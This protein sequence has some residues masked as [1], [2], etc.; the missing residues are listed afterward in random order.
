MTT[1]LA[2][3]TAIRCLLPFLAVLGLVMMAGA[4]DARAY[5]NDRL[6]QEADAFERHLRQNWSAEDGSAGDYRERGNL[7][8]KENMPRAATGA[9]ASAV[10]L[11]KDDATTWLALA[12]AYLAIDP[13]N[14]SE[15]RNFSE[16]ATSAAYLAYQRA[17]SDPLRAA[18]LAELGEGLARRSLWRPAIDAYAASLEVREAKAVRAAYEKLRAERGFRVL[19]Y[20]V[21][22]DAAAPRACVQFSERLAKGVDFAKYI[23]LNGADPAGVAVDDQQVCVEELRH[24][25]RYSLRLRQGLPSAVGETLLKPADLSIYV[26]DRSPSARF[27]GRNYVLPRTGQKGLPVVTVNARELDMALYRI[28]DRRLAHEV[29][30][31][32]FGESLAGYRAEEIKEK[33]GELLWEGQM[34]VEMELNEEVTTAFPV[35]ELQSDLEPGLYVVTAQPASEEAEEWRDRATQWFVISDIGLSAF[36]GTDGI[37]VFARSLASA[38]SLS[39]LEVRLLA[40]NNEVL[41]SVR[42]DESGY[43]SFDPGLTRGEGG[44][45]PAILVAR[46]PEGDYGFLD[47]TKSAFDL[48][49]RGV[50]GRAAPGPLDAMVYAERGV[51]RPGEDVYLTA[52][53]RD[54]TANA[55]SAPL[56]LIVHR[57]DGKEHARVTLEDQGAG[58]RAHTLSLLDE[59]MAGTWRVTAHVDPEAPAIGE[60]AFLVEDYVPQR[61]EMTLTAGDAPASP[62]TPARIMLD[63][64]YLYGAP[65]A[66]L[67]VEG[68]IRLAPTRTV[69]AHPG[70]VFGLAEDE[71]TPA[72]A[73]LSDLPRTDD[74]GRAEITAPL[75]ALPETTR[76]LKADVTL[77]LREPGGRAISE[78]T[79]LPVAGEGTNIGIKP[80][81]DGGR[82]PENSEA[83]F[84]VIAVD[85]EGERIE[86][87]ELTWELLR[88]QRRYQWYSRNGRW[89]YEPVTYTERAA[90]GTLSAAATGE[91]A[92]VTAPVGY[93]RYRLEIARA[94][95][96]PRA[97]PVASYDFTAGWYV[98]DA[99]DSP[100]ILDLSLDRK[101]YRPG[102]TMQVRLAP[103]MAGKAIVSV[104]ADELLATREIEVPADGATVSFTV[105]EEWGPG[106]YVTASLLRPMRA[107][108]GRMPSR[109]VGVAWVPL[110]Q[111]ANRLDVA[112]DAPEK[113]R[114]RQTM[115][116]PVQLSGLREGDTAYL[117]VAAVDVGILN[118]TGYEAPEPD[119]Y[120]LGQ[121]RLG[122]DIRDLYGR[123]IDGMQGTRGTIRTGG[124]GPGGG[125]AM[126]GR[127]RS[128]EPVALY[129]GIV[130]VGPDGSAEVEFDIPAFDGT[131][132]LM[133]TAWSAKQVGHAVS[134][135]TVRDP[136]TLI[137]TAPHFLTIGDTSQVHVSLHNVDGPAGSYSL[138]AEGKGGV[139]LNGEA[140]RTLELDADERADFS[141]PVEAASLGDARVRVTLEGPNGLNIARNYAFPVKPAA[142]NV[143]RRSVQKLAAKSGTLTVTSDLAADL[144]PETVK[145][146]VN[147]GQSAAMD[148]PGLLLALDRFPYGCAEQT[149]SRAL[150]LLYLNEL[151][152]SAGVAGEEGAQA[153]IDKA[154]ARLAALQG[155]SGDFG[156][157]SAGSHNTWLTAYVADFL[158]RARE[159]GFEVREQV[160]A[161]ALDRLRNAVSYAS[162]FS[163]GGEELAYALYVLAR[164]GRA[165]IGDLRYY[166][167]AKLDE[168]ATPL[169]QA[170]IGAALALYGDME[171][172]DK[173]FEAA[174]A[175]LK[176]STQA[177][178]PLRSDFG[179]RLRD[180]AGLVTLAAETRAMS[181]T[182]PQLAGTVAAW[183]ANVSA[184][185]TQE[186]AWLLL[187]AHALSGQSNATELEVDGEA[188]SGPVQ[189]VLSGGELASEPFVV[190]NISDSVTPVSLLVT[191]ASATPEPAAES[192]LSIRRE[193]FTLDG[194]P[195]SLDEVEQNTR[196]VIALTVKEDE[197]LL[198]Q[199]VVEDRLPAGFR[200]E[201][202]R[203]VP[204]SGT[205]ALPWLNTSD[206]AAHTAF[207]DD[208]FMAA[209]SLT[210]RGRKSPETLRM[211]Y[212]VRAVT[213]GEYVNGGA[214][215][216]DMY[217]PERFARTAPGKVK[218][219]G[220]EE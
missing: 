206:G 79:N 189:R 187:A 211:A 6:A 124:D 167:D 193:V 99:A 198:G 128:V 134:D 219:L 5:T 160:L 217:R 64:R 156:L 23:S 94:S 196:Y 132:R 127:P 150:P 80:Q 141:L 157:W 110:D 26:R 104:V 191:G 8:R 78:T 49:D 67:Q 37:H 190:R 103:R 208:S 192:G 171:R 36:S 1:S 154:I 178:T 140:E 30:E 184:T 38:E 97:M 29:L 168:F 20:T 45:S 170:Q 82:V 142:P 182:L 40:R 9:Y 116:L 98:A 63:G 144:I 96:G 143:K 181:E 24:G 85:G 155:T 65:A 153:R 136:V 70:Y 109:A 148:V 59:A 87:G 214:K 93:G 60:T 73:P 48:T 19:D 172:A 108:A 194:E 17:D 213:P 202:P 35:D 2:R 115:S 16:N 133:A 27:S 46:T 77:R 11:D 175:R 158:L 13:A 125:M 52:L 58:G 147:V 137:G 130:E 117:T 56:T 3:L 126:E 205:G 180:S 203:L 15:E 169:A 210:E 68:E 101:S 69:D 62:E 81:F 159:E 119:S 207:R 53:L 42:T 165:V 218:I 151:A 176:P 149:V 66:G 31:G 179:S 18:A 95:D 121:R 200:I 195:V 105:R 199:L 55:A 28:G 107:E 90:S 74:E 54:D 204:S 72:R 118:L 185:T 177:Q 51:Y 216:E 163:D 174:L 122:M 71:A 114:P 10:V 129:S 84:D 12:R 112:L 61:M 88:V 120:F 139:S 22:S 92:G 113:M 89:D 183:R 32:A 106:A 215:V 162:D 173:A 209:F 50:G 86:S 220:A 83:G 47:I 100:D 135:V 146:A 188:H 91:P 43:A 123:L 41:Q 76:P 4:P 7:A 33:H 197:P 164:A 166:A 152:E 186:N 34:P 102:E 25:E 161:P 145:V 212:I 57:P 14:Y 21:E 75:P 131:L 39:G 44:M 201:N 111:G 138:T